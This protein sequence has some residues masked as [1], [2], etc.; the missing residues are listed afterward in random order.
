[1]PINTFLPTNIKVVNALMIIVKITLN[2]TILKIPNKTGF[3]EVPS[4]NLFY[5]V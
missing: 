4:V 1:M 3:F 5:L 2:L